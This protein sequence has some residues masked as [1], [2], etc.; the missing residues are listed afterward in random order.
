MSGSSNPQNDDDDDGA[1]ISIQ[2]AGKWIWYGVGAF[3]IIMILAVNLKSCHGSDT[4]GASHNAAPAQDAAA[5]AAA[6]SASAVAANAAVNVS[7]PTNQA[8]TPVC[9]EYDTTNHTC[10]IPATGT[11]K[12]PVVT[13]VQDMKDG[14]NVT[15]EQPS[16]QA[17]TKINWWDQAGE[18]HTQTPTGGAPPDQAAFI[19][20]IPDTSKFAP[21]QTT[22]TSL[23]F[24][25]S[26]SC[27]HKP[28]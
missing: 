1:G 22:L 12:V 28:A 2:K 13:T 18:M 27:G 24:M 6:A 26:A 16:I 10:N 5:S 14:W 15:C 3:F 19:E 23:Y 11:G 9:G 17:Y 7:V 4:G 20:K 8:G 21:G 25:G